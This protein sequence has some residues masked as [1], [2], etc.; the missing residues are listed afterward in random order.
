M[1]Y[2]KFI[3]KCFNN[4]SLKIQISLRKKNFNRF[5]AMVSWKCLAL[6][7]ENLVFYGHN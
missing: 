6:Q 2:I 1:G 5:L 4:F 3:V 7:V